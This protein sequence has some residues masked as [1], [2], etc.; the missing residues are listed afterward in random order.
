MQHGHLGGERGVALVVLAHEH[1]LVLLLLTVAL[2]ALARDAYLLVQRLEHTRRIVATSVFQSA[3]LFL[4]R[5][6]ELA[7]LSAS[8]GEQRLLRRNGRLEGVEVAE[9]EDARQLSRERRLL[10]H[11]VLQLLL[12]IR[13]LSRLAVAVGRR[14]FSG[15]LLALVHWLLCDVA[16]VLLPLGHDDLLLRLRPLEGTPRLRQS[17][18]E[19]R[20]PL[21][22]RVERKTLG[23][24]VRR[25]LRARRPA[26]RL[27][28]CRQLRRRRRF[29]RRR[30][31][32][33]ASR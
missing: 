27:R 1:L 25:R 13:E 22:E 15:R 16:A 32:P 24:H 17:H 5:A 12:R 21:C 33:R 18:L 9:G 14:L 30:T 26:S 28:H 20:I 8:V 11:V 23:R 3:R 31:A 2:D 7:A 19:R 29:R 4:V 10:L 6:C